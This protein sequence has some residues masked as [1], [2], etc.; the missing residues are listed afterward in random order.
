MKSVARPRSPELKPLWSAPVPPD[1]RVIAYTVGRDREVDREF[2]VWDVLGSLGHV[3]GL[4]ASGL[5]SAREHARLRSGL[6]RALDS[7]RRGELS[8]GAEHEDGHSALEAWLVAQLGATGERVHTGRSRNDQVAVAIRLHA[9]W[10]L[11]SIHAAAIR[12]V[13]VFL[14]VADRHRSRLWPGYTHLR[15]AMPSSVGL[16]SSAY[17][18][19]LVEVL[20]S[21][22]ALWARV[23]RCPLGSAAGY[24]VPLALDRE[25]TARSLG[26]REPEPN[27]AL[28]QN[29]RGK[30]EAAILFFCVEL[31]HEL[32]RFTADV[33]LYS[34]EEFGYLRLPPALATGSSIMPQKRNPD[35]FELTRAR[36]ATLEGEFV[37]LLL[38][39]GK[40]T[41]GYHRDFQLLKEPYLRGVGQTSDMLEAMAFAAPLLE[42]DAERAWAALE[43]GSLATDEVLRRV[44]GGEPFRSAYRAVAS[45]LRGGAQ[46]DVPPASAILE[47]R[48]ST[49]NAG[50]LGLDK[51][52]RRT[53]R[54][55]SWAESERVS[56]TRALDTLAGGRSKWAPIENNVWSGSSNSSQPGRFTPKKNSRPRSSAPATTSPSLRSAA[57]SPPSAS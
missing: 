12:L 2:L 22:P 51:L 7:V 20:E 53:E 10:T 9:K 38:L 55:A 26:F 14:D 6:R 1:P 21:L 34:S 28:V 27:V 25:A 52:S 42:Y 3:E 31:A 33:V 44:E 41:S 15:R 11:L 50:N 5:L 13:R 4:R 57:T 24:G 23:D 29:G 32:S 8:I 39:K 46:F 35:L 45:E 37:T 19:G 54:A 16:W 48:R 43:G 36:A 47:R 30:L 49:G 17:A 56:F 40:L 18:A